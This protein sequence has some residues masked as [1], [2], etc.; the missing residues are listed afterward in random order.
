MLLNTSRISHFLDGITKQLGD[1]FHAGLLHNLFS[2]H[3][4]NT[5]ADVRRTGN[6]PAA[7]LLPSHTHC[8]ISIWAGVNGQR[9][10]SKT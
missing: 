5:L 7:G 4:R 1:V 10:G 3:V 9:L 6:L 2:G 8:R